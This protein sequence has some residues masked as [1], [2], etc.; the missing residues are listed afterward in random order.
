MVNQNRVKKQN[1]FQIKQ[2]PVIYWMQRDQRVEDNWAL[3]YAQQ[4]AEENQQPL[5]AVFCL[6][7]NFLDAGLRH[8]Q[9]MLDGLIETHKKLESINIRFQLL[10]GN[11]TDQIP[12]FL[13]EVKAGA[14]VSD[15][16][17]L[18]IAREW[19]RDVIKKVEIPF[20]TVDAHNIIPCWITSDKEEFA[21]YTI[22]PK[23]HRLLPDYLEE[24]PK[25]KPQSSELFESSEIDWEKI[26][27]ELKLDESVRAVDWIK[28]GESEARI[29]LEIFLTK[30][31]KV[32]DTDR[33]DPTKDAVSNLS[34]YL[35]FGHISAQRIALEVH[36]IEGVDES[37]KSFL[38]E[39]I[40][41]RELTDNFCFYNKNYDNFDGLRDW[42]KNTLNQHRSDKR[43]Y[44]YTQSEFENASTHE[45]LWNAAQLQLVKSGKMAGYMRMY[46][47]KKI[48]EWSKSPEQ[49]MEIAIYLN[50][51]YS[52]DGRDPNGYVGVAWSIGGIHDRAWTERPVYGKIRYMNYN[53]AKR[54]FDVKKYIESWVD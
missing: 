46:W 10:L 38:E 9:F 8:Y 7:N 15:F 13:T 18:K 3:L 36:E 35:H 28:P 29:T 4:I 19:K 11:P 51:K 22:R 53:G 44:I 47:A 30:K 1:D 50:D 27:S 25:L 16:S 43:E 31:I 37:K 21:A 39:L 17:P 41:R 2:G 54:K 33:N 24:F 12:K 45:E 32:Y 14:I 5:I 26:M 40:V 42:A 23:V 48:L 34:P 49:A 52:L 6:V 20:F